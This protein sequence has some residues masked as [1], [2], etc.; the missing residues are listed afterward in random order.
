MEPMIYSFNLRDRNFSN[1]EY[2]SLFTLGTYFHWDRDCRQ[3]GVT[4]YT[5]S[6]LND[7]TLKELG[8]K[9]AWLV[10]PYAVLQ[11]PYLWIYKNYK[12]FV[13]VWTHDVEVLKRVPNSYFV[14]AG[15][16]WIEPERICIY[17][18][19][20]L[21]SFIASAKT[22]TQGHKLRQKIRNQLPFGIPQF[23]RDF[24]E[25]DPKS[26]ALERYAFSIV[27]E[28]SFRDAYFSEKIIDCFLTGTVPIYW[29]TRKIADHFDSNG[30]IFFKD[31]KELLLILK[32]LSFENYE[33]RQNAIAKNFELAKRFILAEEWGIGYLL[34]RL[35][36][37]KL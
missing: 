13:M 21:C 12:S 34:N 3:S 23:G 5:D 8:E 15:G 30:V 6:Y 35:V 2:S 32:K 33:A 17:P 11:S 18:K 19:T 14:P 24:N 20:Q 9:I 37:Q 7:P 26:K 1:Q 29:G 25:I 10:E 22:D 4:V 28:N 16:C 31:I 27:V 36:D